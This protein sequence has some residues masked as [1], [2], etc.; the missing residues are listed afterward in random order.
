MLRFSPRH[1][2]AIGCLLG[3]PLTISFAV[4]AATDPHSSSTPATATASSDAPPA[5]YTAE[6]K[7]TG[8][9]TQ[10]HDSV[11]SRY[12]YAFGK[13]HPFLPSNAM[14]SNGQFVNPRTVPTAE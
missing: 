3:L 1:F 13:E 14:T 9:K 6:I 5:A 2:A 7:V 4:R 11:T 12:N 10:F 8:T